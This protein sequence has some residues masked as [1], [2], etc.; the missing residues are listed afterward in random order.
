MSLGTS[1]VFLAALVEETQDLTLQI[2]DLSYG[3]L[4]AA[5]SM[6]VPSAIPHAH[7][8][9]TVANDGQVL[10]T[11]SPSSTRE[12]VVAPKRSS[13]YIVPVD[14]RLK[15]NLAFALGKTA[16]TA[17]WLTPKKSDAQEDDESAKIISDIRSFLKKGNAQKAEQAFLKWVDKHS[18]RTP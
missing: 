18:V 7:L 15:S 9:L 2:W 16:L 13:I 14:P 5:R 12:K 11:V 17:E 1:L 3:I 8:S 10:L 6:P 4:L